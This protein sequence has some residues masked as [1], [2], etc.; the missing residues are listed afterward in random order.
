MSRATESNPAAR[1]AILPKRAGVYEEK[2][3]VTASNKME[4]GSRLGTRCETGAC[5]ALQRANILAGNVLENK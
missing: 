2:E 3:G 4:G 1:I 5:Q